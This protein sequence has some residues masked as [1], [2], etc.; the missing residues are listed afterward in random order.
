MT[1]LQEDQAL[2]DSLALAD[3]SPDER[4]SAIVHLAGTHGFNFSAEECRTVLE[5]VRKSRDGELG[6]TE[7]EA[8]VGGAVAGE[9]SSL[10][11]QS[12]FS[13]FLNDLFGPFSVEP[14]PE[15][16]ETVVEARPR[17]TP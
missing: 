11:T 1:K 4:I 9:F 17:F 7:L 2:R 6:E 8:V 13:D 10:T 3:K 16:D 5:T 15:E 12:G 14:T